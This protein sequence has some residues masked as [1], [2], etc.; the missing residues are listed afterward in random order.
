MSAF[1][2]NL[3]VLHSLDSSMCAIWQHPAS[4]PGQ[5]RGLHYKCL[6]KGPPFP[7]SPPSALTKLI[8]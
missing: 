2:S 3:V 1:E 8:T 5:D 4:T 7:F 6:T